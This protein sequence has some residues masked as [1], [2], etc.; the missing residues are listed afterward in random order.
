MRN[1]HFPPTHSVGEPYK[2]HAL[3]DPV[4]LE[5]RWLI[6]YAVAVRKTIPPN[7]N[8]KPEGICFGIPRRP[9]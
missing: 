6:I 8:I 7:T 1:N 2:N 4:P 9:D 5:A 3:S